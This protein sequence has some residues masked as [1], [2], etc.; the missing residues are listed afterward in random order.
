MV[1]QALRLAQDPIR[2]RV[3][4]GA[5]HERQLTAHPEPVEGWSGIRRPAAHSS[6]CEILDL[7][8]VDYGQ[9]LSLQEKCRDAVER[10]HPGFW[11]FLQHPPVVTTGRRPES[12][13]DL[14][15]GSES[16]R[17][18]GVGFAQT[19]RGG[20]LTYHHPGQIIGYPIL[21]LRRER[22][23]LRTYIDRLAALIS[24]TLA[25]FGLE[26][27]FHPDH[28][29]LWV[30]SG[31]GTLKIASIGVHVRRSIT[32]HGFALNVHRPTITVSG[33]KMC[34]M[35]ADRFTSME[36]LLR[37]PPELQAVKQTL[38]RRA[39]RMDETHG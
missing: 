30:E 1:R 3:Y 38:M 16:L 13:S 10:G 12:L 15:G 31:H 34:G 35:E 24:G 33:L 8:E 14:P 11:L 21:D 32:T 25:T 36:D 17:P 39:E 19:D 5:H 28:P 22:W 23:K 29:G 7:E 37:H 6:H 18:L 4:R 2:S 9:A 27:R 20:R 26:A